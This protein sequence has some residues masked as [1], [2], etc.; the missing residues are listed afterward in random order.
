MAPF[1]VEEVRALAAADPQ[2][3][4]GELAGRCPFHRGPDGTVTLTRMGDIAA[5]NRR[6]DVLGPG[7]NGPMMGGQRPLIPLDLDGPEHL[8]FRRLLDPLF[9]AKKAAL[10]E[11]E[12]RKLADQLIDGFID[13]KEV[14]LQEAF[15][16]PLPSIFFLRLM[17]NPAGRS[18]R[19]PLLQGR[20]PRPPPARPHPR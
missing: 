7:A 2:P 17:G 3:T 15:C 13:R 20:H 14:D 6:H 11:P 9:S 10:L 16:Q 5:V 18:R 1:S 4:Y 12:V 8:K 19:V